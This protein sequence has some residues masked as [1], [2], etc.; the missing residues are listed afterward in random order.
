VQSWLP[1]VLYAA[2]ERIGGL[3]GVRLLIG[4]LTAVLTGITWR[5]L[6]PM[7]GLVP[8]LAV[9]AMF[10]TI[11]IGV[12]SERPFM[13]GLIAFGLV[14]LAAEGA[15]DPR[16]LVPLGWLWANSHGSF[17]L[18]LVYLAVVLIGSRL[19]G[20]LDRHAV[21]S[22]AWLGVGVLTGAVGPLGARV[23]TFPIE[24]LKRQDL[25]AN[26]I[27]W[28]APTFVSMAERAFLAQVAVAIIFLVR[29][30][31]YRSSLT[32]AVFVGAA[33]LGSRNISVAS[34]ALLPGLAQGLRGIGSISGSDRSRL[35]VPMVALLAVLA[36]LVTLARLQER[37]LDLRA[38]P[39]DLLAYLEAQHVDL[40]DDRMAGPE[41]VGNLITYVY[42]N[43]GRRVFYDDRFDMYPQRASDAHLA[44]KNA[45]R[46]VFVDLAGYDVDLVVIRVDHP[47]G[48][49]LARDPAWR[50]LY[51]GER[52]QL[53]CRRGAS[54]SG[55]IGMC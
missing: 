26:V 20:S 37:S 39:L 32:L 6:Q 34:L 40:R 31:T 16:W 10:V 11:G 2:A 36:P 46:T 7:E 41:L 30:P 17:P 24:L 29:R 33:L 1:S 42:G 23:L 25:L 28:Q 53:S 52:W 45:E 27:E 21:R 50:M 14:V 54:I 15:F 3:D 13:V 51:L 35:V 4:L 9:V 8:R 55:A 12:W 44:L 38:Y 47:T 18:G 5:I 43:D 48:F 49:M 22:L 19:D